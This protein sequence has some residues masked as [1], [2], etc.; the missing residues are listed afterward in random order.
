MLIKIQN[1]LK[2][3]D[4]YNTE[5]CFLCFSELVQDLLSIV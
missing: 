3:Y 5:K 2:F 1:T 4:F